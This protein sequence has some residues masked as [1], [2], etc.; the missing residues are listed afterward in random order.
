VLRRCCHSR[1]SEAAATTYFLLQRPDI[2]CCAVLCCVCRCCHS[3]ASEAAAATGT[4]GA[5][6]FR[7]QQRPAAAAAQPI[8][9]AAAARRGGGEQCVD[10]PAALGNRQDARLVLVCGG[11]GVKGGGGRGEG[12]TWKQCVDRPAAVRVGPHTRCVHER[13]A[14]IS[15]HVG[16]LG[17]AGGGGGRGDSWKARCWE[18]SG[19]QWHLQAH[20]CATLLAVRCHVLPSH[21]CPL[22]TLCSVPSYTQARMVAGRYLN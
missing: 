9:A 4:G 14:V 2:P 15:K 16:Q 21:P 17:V 12:G 20:Q 3:R 7:Q 13:Q 1:A 5:R 8:W 18:G 19:K 22:P 11:E 6:Q 10:G